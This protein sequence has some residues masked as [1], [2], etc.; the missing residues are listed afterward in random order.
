ME[1][2]ATFKEIVREYGSVA[3]FLL[4]Y[5]AEA[6]PTDGWAFANNKYQIP[7]HI[8]IQDRVK[9]AEK[10]MGEGLVCP[11]VVDTMTDQASKLYRATP[12]RLAIVKDKKL[13]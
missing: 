13:V 7:N 10:L 8:N 12:E 2:L 4:I 11:I 6:H 9:A 5:I 3:D 1:K